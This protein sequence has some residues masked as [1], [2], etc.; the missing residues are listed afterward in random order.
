MSLNSIRRASSAGYR[1]PERSETA[2]RP[3][4][5]RQPPGKTRRAVPLQTFDKTDTDKR[6][7]VKQDQVWRTIV[8][9]ESRG[10][11]EWEK[12]WG[13]LKNY[14]QMGQLK[15]AEPLPSHTSHS[16]QFPNTSNQMIGSRLSTPLGMELI[17]LDRLTRS[18][19]KRK[20]DPAVMPY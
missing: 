13:F 3:G 7:P 18:H 12:N 14:D 20:Q 8:E 11:E 6:D 15:P 16:D 10:L 1:L 4:T 17:K 2:G 5:S 9:F 19:Y